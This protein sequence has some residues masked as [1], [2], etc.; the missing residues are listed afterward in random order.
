[1]AQPAHLVTLPPRPAPSWGEFVPTAADELERSDRTDVRNAP[2]AAAVPSAAKWFLRVLVLALAIGGPILAF[3]GERKVTL[4]V[5]G[6]VRSVRTY[7]ADA[8]T[9]LERKG[10]APAE[11]DL[12]KTKG[13]ELQHVE[14]RRAKQIRLVL[15]GKRETVVARGLTVGEALRDLGMQPGPKDH[16]YPAATSELRPGLQVFVRNAI[17][18]KLRVDGRLRDVVS[19]ADTIENLLRQAGVSV[20]ESDYVIPS[21]ETEPVDGMW[22]RVVR[23]R[24]TVEERSVRVPFHVETRHDPEMESGVRRVV[25]EG[26]EGLKVQRYAVVLEDGVRVSTRLIGEDVVRAAR[27]HVVRVGTKEPT[28]KGGGGTQS[29]VASWFEA[30]GLVAAHRSLPIG[31]VVKVTGENGKSVT[32]R[33]NQRGP[34]VEG[35]VIDLSDDAFQRL[36]PLGQGTIKVT[37]HS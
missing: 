8:T 4:D 29:G 25:Q 13:H 3:R 2:R 30:D 10:L 36:A 6:T 27:A 16:L 24:R 22:I 32:V 12:V 19:S 18:A 17:H 37:V 35:R 14:Y 11:D 1:M 33:I 21:R 34:F 20:G 26:A 9:L 31:S 23:V 15:D 28:F 5:E 7:A